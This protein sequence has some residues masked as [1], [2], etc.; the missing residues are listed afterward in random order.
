M[1]LSKLNW[2]FHFAKKSAA[3]AINKR[4]LFVFF[5]SFCTFKTFL[6]KRFVCVVQTDALFKTHISATATD[7]KKDCSLTE[8]LHQPLPIT[9]SHGGGYFSVV[10]AS[11][12]RQEN[13]ILIGC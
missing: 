3:W 9:G 10:L 1:A 11:E 8:R 13:G 6:S 12:G 2:D 4:F 5:F 7:K